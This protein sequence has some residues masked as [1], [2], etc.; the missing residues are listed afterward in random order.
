VSK[1]IRA[2]GGDE[3]VS[4]GGR[5]ET[6]ITSIQSPV[7]GSAWTEVKVGWTGSGADGTAVVEVGGD[8]DTITQVLETVLVMEGP[9]RFRE[10]RLGYRALLG[11]KD[12]VSVVH[13]PFRQP[14]VVAGA[15][16]LFYGRGGAEFLVARS[17]VDY[18]AN[19]TVTANGP[20][21]VSPWIGDWREGDR[22]LIRLSLEALQRG[23]V[24]VVLGWKDRVL[25]DDPK[26][27]RELIPRRE[28]GI[29]PP[30]RVH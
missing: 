3:A 26:G 8:L 19:G 1:P 29:S 5:G 21:D 14:V 20:A 2:L 25:R 7:G 15:R 13:V 4:L 18:V 10:Q 16:E 17:Q 9:A 30:A 11:P 23:P 28:S 27:D 24:S 22:L 12:H 6:R